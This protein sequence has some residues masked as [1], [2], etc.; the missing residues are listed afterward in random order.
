MLFRLLYVALYAVC[1]I[2]LATIY[3]DLKRNGFARKR[4]GS[5]ERKNALENEKSKKML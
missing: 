5:G 2:F 1:Y 4:N 3:V